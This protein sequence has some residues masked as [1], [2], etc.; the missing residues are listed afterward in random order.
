MLALILISSKQFISIYEVTSPEMLQLLLDFTSWLTTP[1]APFQIL[2]NTYPHCEAI[3]HK[4]AKGSFLSWDLAIH[5]K[6]SLAP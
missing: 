2:V 6:N 3:V 4:V 1:S 5:L